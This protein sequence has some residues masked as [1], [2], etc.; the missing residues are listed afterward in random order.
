[1]RSLQERRAWGALVAAASLVGCA[2]S[3][4]AVEPNP[5]VPQARL[6]SGERFATAAAA[7]SRGDLKA[8]EGEMEAVVAEEPGHGLAWYNLG[9]AREKLGRAN[10]AAEAYRRAV[11]TGGPSEAK[12]N[13]AVLAAQKGDRRE[14][15][16]LL[17]EL[18]A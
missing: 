18:V 8:V 14:A 15:V 2:G 10:A 17:R 13:L 3:S 16:V 1:M 5:V 11:A 7:E 9:V 12:Q 6:S 4:T